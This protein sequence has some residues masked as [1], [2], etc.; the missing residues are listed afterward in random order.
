MA[1]RENENERQTVR[2]RLERKSKWTRKADL[3]RDGEGAVGRADGAGAE[4]AHASLLLHGLRSHLGELRR[5]VV[6]FVH[7]VLEPVVRLAAQKRER[8]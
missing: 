6:D 3:G 1:D 8:T 2:Q 5:L 7:E 4:L